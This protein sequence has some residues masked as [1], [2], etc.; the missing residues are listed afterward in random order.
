MKKLSMVLV[1]VFLMTMGTLFAQNA[2]YFG[3]VAFTRVEIEGIG[4]IEAND[5]VNISG[6]F[7]IGNVPGNTQAPAERETSNIT[8]TR[9]YAGNSDLYDWYSRFQKGTMDRR[10]LSIIF[11]YRNGDELSRYNLFDCEPVNYKV[12]VRKNK[13]YEQIVLAHRDSN[14][15]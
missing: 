10:S 15:G 5:L 14:K 1:L 4:M 3:E 7:H 9:V 6:G 2:S 13:V 12:I 11:L 8:I